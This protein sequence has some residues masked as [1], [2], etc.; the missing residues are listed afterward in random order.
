MTDHHFVTRMTRVSDQLSTAIYNRTLYLSDYC[1][2]G[3]EYDILQRGR[4][5]K[6]PGSCTGPWSWECSAWQTDRCTVRR[7][8]LSDAISDGRTEDLNRRTHCP[9][10]R[11]RI[12]ASTHS[13]A[14]AWL[15]PS[16]CAARTIIP[17]AHT[18]IWVSHV[19]TW[20]RAAHVSLLSM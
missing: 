17:H 1:G 20:Y 10:T 9:W 16:G 12:T 4:T 13:Q 8:P 18:H 6:I 3:H 19:R 11:T 15:P 14:N 5:G 2:G 7:Y